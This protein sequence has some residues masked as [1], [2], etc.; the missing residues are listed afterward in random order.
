M[1]LHPGAGRVL[2]PWPLRQAMCTGGQSQEALPSSDAAVM[3]ANAVLLWATGMPAA[4][5]I[6]MY[7]LACFGR[8]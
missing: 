4:L 2:T 5:G 3:A 6:G 7:L 8:A 1:A